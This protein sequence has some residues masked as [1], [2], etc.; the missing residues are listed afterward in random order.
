MPPPGA[1]EI[2]YVSGN[3]RLRAWVDAVRGGAAKPAVLFLHG[4]FAFGAEDWEQAQPF[5]DAGFITMTPMVRG[6]NG[7]PGFYSM[8]YDEIDDV[9]AAAETL[10]RLPGVDPN[11]IFVAGHS[12]GGTLTLLAAMTSK[13]FRAAASFSGSCD[14]V[15]FARGQM[16]LVPFE[17][18]NQREYQ[19]RSPLAFP[20]SFKCPVR[21][22]Y[23]SLEPFFRS[24]SEK[25]AELARKAGLDVSAASVPGDHFTS[26]LPAMRQAIA[27]FQ[28]VK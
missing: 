16:E 11:R 24:S 25:T 2:E 26:V 27:F 4:G 5:R 21:I 19:M 1:Q 15:E 14:Q 7:L 9:V 12:A 6:E 17:P 23:G 3:L 10:A 22:Y 28:Q 13:R 20:R 8:F 18:N